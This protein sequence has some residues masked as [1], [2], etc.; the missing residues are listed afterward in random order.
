M[1]EDPTPGDPRAHRLDHWPVE[2]VR[3]AAV[4]YLRAKGAHGVEVIAVDDAAKAWL[5]AGGDEAMATYIPRVLRAVQERHPDWFN[6]PSRRLSDLRDRYFRRR[7]LP[8]P[9]I[10]RDLPNLDALLAAEEQIAAREGGPEA[11]A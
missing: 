9:Q 10:E 7:G 8:Y 1:T 6:A 4:A 2:A 3:A 11:G 5:A